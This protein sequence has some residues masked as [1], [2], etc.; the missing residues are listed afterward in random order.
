[1]ALTS[2]S[3]SSSNRRLTSSVYSGDDTIGDLIHQISQ[4]VELQELR[5]IVTYQEENRA[6][7]KSLIFTRGHGM[8]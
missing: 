7:E 1:M 8:G 5:A 4:E 3:K 2:G 6:I